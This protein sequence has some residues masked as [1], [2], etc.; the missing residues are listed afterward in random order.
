MKFL[1]RGHGNEAV[2]KTGLEEQQ[3]KDP[4]WLN[5]DGR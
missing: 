4:W 3:K 5:A 1:S 2:S